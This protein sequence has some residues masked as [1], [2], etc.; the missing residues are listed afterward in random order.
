MWSASLPF[1]AVQTV[2]KA[3]EISIATSAIVACQSMGGAVFV[4]V[5]NTILQNQLVDGGI[6]EILV[7]IDIDEIIHAGATRF[8]SIIPQELL[9]E[10]LILYNAA[11]QKVFY[12]AVGSAGMAFLSSLPMEWNS[13]KDDKNKKQ[14]EQKPVADG[15]ENV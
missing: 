11:L 3:E 12:L 6:A 14:K 7:Q 9:P 2:V 10:F 8:R 1:T 5:G 15:P 13:V 4:S